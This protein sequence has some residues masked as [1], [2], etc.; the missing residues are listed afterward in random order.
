LKARAG[1]PWI[2]N[3]ARLIGRNHRCDIEMTRRKVFPAIHDY[4]TVATENDKKVQWKALGF[5]TAC[6][7]SS[8]SHP[9]HRSRQATIGIIHSFG[10][11]FTPLV[12]SVEQS[13]QIVPM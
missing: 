9:G 12:L 10:V 7:S 11:I 5:G 8:Y 4:G 3:A 6:Q 2:G 1:A 13:I